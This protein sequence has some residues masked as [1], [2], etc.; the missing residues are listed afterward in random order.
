MK[1][2]MSDVVGFYLAILGMPAAIFLG[3]KFDSWWFAVAAIQ[4]PNLIKGIYFCFTKKKIVIK[5]T[6][7]NKAKVA[8]ALLDKIDCEY[9]ESGSWM[10]FDNFLKE[11]LN[12]WRSAK[13]N[14]L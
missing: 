14:H 6:S 4:L 9:A 12:E 8:I 1:K 11:R 13:A 3:F 5:F 2:R 10:Q 7:L